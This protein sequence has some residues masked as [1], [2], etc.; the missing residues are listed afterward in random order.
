[1]TFS[2]Y[3]AL[4]GHKGHWHFNHIKYF[5][6]LTNSKVLTWYAR[7]WSQNGRRS[8]QFDCGR[9]FYGKIGLSKK[10]DI[11]VWYLFRGVHLF[12]LWSTIENSWSTKAWSQR[13][14]WGAKRR[15][16]EG[17]GG[18]HPLPQVGVRGSP[19]RNF[20]KIASKWY[21]LVHFGAV[22]ANFKTKNLYEKNASLHVKT[23]DNKIFN[24]FFFLFSCI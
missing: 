15:K 17:G 10:V 11:L 7:N 20:W 6:G 24:R 3:F 23:S 4:I 19:P 2:L 13:V 21:I 14:H 5:G 1:M 12:F 22:N 9:T 8:G 16:G 18:G